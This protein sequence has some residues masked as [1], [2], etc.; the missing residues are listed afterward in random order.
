MLLAIVTPQSWK[1]RV[2]TTCMVVFVLS[3]CSSTLL[4][5]GISAV[6]EAVGNDASTL[7]S[8]SVLTIQAVF[9]FVASWFFEWWKNNPKLAGISNDTQLWVQRLVAAVVAIGTSVGIGYNFDPVAGTL[10]LTGLTWN[11]IMWGGWE[12]FKQFMIQEFV[13]RSAFK[14]KQQ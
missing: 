3:V 6:A 13:Y 8:E 9:A 2:W 7:P 11:G 1:V 5:Q 12:A 14:G 4:A 10:L